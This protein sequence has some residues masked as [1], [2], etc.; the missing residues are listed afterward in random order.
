[1]LISQFLKRFKKDNYFY[2]V[3]R[4][5]HLVVVPPADSR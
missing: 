3:L 5:R 2:G 1:M 4:G